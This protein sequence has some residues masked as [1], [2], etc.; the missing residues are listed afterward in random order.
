[1]KVAIIGAGP[2]G[3][4]AGYELSKHNI[5]VDIFES[6][7]SVGGMSKTIELWNQKVDIGSHRFF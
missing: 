1:M 4:T 5:S 3:I 2:A 6:S 7:S